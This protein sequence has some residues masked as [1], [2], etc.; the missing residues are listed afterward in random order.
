M[1]E[2]S[3]NPNRLLDALLEHLKLENDNALSKKLKVAR[4]V[5][6]DIRSSNLHIGASM[7]MW[8]HEATGISIN[9]LR[10]LLGDR[11]TKFRVARVIAKH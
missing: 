9:E 11:R 2:Q 10:G 3:Y 6:S 8:M 4:H 7:I 5:I 1:A